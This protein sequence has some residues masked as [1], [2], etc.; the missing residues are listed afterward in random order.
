MAPILLEW[1]ILWVYHD[2][3]LELVT[4]FGLL[5][6]YAGCMV[7]V[8]ICRHYFTEPIEDY[9]YIWFSWITQIL[10]LLCVLREAK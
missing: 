1:M 3:F 10:A 7:F 5:L 2:W 6:R 4:V 8:G 9:A